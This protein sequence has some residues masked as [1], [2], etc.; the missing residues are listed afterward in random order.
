[1]LV[2]VIILISALTILPALALG[3]LVEAAF[4]WEVVLKWLSSCAAR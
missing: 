2:G 3:P 1:M 4:E